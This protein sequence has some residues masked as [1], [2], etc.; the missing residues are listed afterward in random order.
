MQAPYQEHRGESSREVRQVLSRGGLCGRVSG[1]RSPAGLW[2]MAERTPGL[3]SP[4]G[5]LAQPTNT[6]AEDHLWHDL[7]GTSSR[8]RP[9]LRKGDSL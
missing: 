5:H 9:Q 8:P 6:L 7:L 1:A 4:R 2:E 3:P